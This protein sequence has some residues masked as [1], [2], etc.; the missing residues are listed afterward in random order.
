LIGVLA[1]ISMA[2]LAY[3]GAVA[4][5]STDDEVNRRRISLVHEGVVLVFI[6]SAILVLAI[7]RGIESEGAVSIISAIA[8]YVFGRARGML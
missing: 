5:Y 2:V 4:K 8:G 7:G 3:V 1:I 6:V